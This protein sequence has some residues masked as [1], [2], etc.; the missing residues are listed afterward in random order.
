MTEA[1]PIVHLRC[2]RTKRVYR[3]VGV[4]PDTKI[5]TLRGKLGTF[6]EPWDPPKLKEIGYE[7]VDGPFEGMIE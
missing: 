4:D 6:T 3:V 7:K 5:V 1:A 2:K